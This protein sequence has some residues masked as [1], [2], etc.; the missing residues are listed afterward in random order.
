[1]ICSEMEGVEV[2]SSWKTERTQ[3]MNQWAFW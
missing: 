2:W 3:E 1:M